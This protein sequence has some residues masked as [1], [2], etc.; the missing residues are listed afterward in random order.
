MHSLS[1]CGTGA[2][3]WAARAW[4]LHGIWALSSP[5]KAWTCGLHTVRWI[6][7]HWATREVPSG[8]YF[9]H[10]WNSHGNETKWNWVTCQMPQL[11]SGRAKTGIQ[12]LTPE[13]T[14]LTPT[15]LLCSLSSRQWVWQ[16]L[17][18]YGNALPTPEQDLSICRCFPIMEMDGWD[19]KKL[20]LYKTLKS[21]DWKLSVLGLMN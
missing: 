11:T 14:L 21:S 4:T 19:F 7:N 16:R 2:H 17:R 1:S 20:M 12:V 8:H 6:P 18:N 15:H 9:L 5:T 3:W 13:P 10:S